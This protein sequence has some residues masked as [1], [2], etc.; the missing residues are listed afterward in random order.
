[1]RRWFVF[2]LVVFVTAFAVNLMVL[3]AWSPSDVDPYNA[4]VIAAVATA[5]IT[6]L[7]RTWTK[8]DS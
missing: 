4:I 2:A 5:A 6:F 3:A 1:M 8:H 7:E